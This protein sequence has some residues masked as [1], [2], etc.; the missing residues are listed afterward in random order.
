LSTKLEITKVNRFDSKWDAKTMF[1]GFKIR[2]VLKKSSDTITNINHMAQLR[3]R[4]QR[5]VGVEGEEWLLQA[6]AHTYDDELYLKNAGKLIM[7]KLQDHEK[8]NLLFERIEQHKD[9]DELRAE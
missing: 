8:F 4:L 6:N 2:A 7:W 1:T 9:D 5:E 3:R